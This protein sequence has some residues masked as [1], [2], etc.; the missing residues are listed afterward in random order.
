[1]SRRTRKLS[2][3][4]AVCRVRCSAWL[5]RKRKI[6][7]TQSFYIVLC[8]PQQDLVNAPLGLCVVEPLN[9]RANLIDRVPLGVLEFADGLRSD[10]FQHPQRHAEWPRILRFGDVAP[11]AVTGEPGESTV[12]QVQLVVSELPNEM[13]VRQRGIVHP[14]NGIRPTE[15]RQVDIE[16]FLDRH[17]L[18]QSRTEE[19]LA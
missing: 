17:Q 3:A 7:G 1:M 8:H 12:V 18:S 6:L 15:I 14:E 19:S 2:G 9:Y 5:G 4:A 10:A 11:Q 16:Y 13:Q